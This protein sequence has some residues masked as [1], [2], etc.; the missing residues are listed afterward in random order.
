METRFKVPS[1]IGSKIINFILRKIA[2]F[3]QL[4]L[5][6]SRRRI[7]IAKEFSTNE[8]TEGVT[9][10]GDVVEFRY[11]PK[12]GDSEYKSHKLSHQYALKI[13]VKFHFFKSI[14]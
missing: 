2:P 6:D 10:I 1:T 5:Q 4:T 14:Y 12:K 8:I 3:P 11:A 7:K 9:L 13:F